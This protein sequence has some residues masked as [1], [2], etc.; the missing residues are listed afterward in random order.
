MVNGRLLKWGGRLLGV[1]TDRVRPAR[2]HQVRDM[3][4]GIGMGKSKDSAI[5]LGPALV[6]VDELEPCRRD[7]RLAME[8]S[9]TVNGEQLTRG[10]LDRMDWSFGELIAYVS[11]GTDVPPGSVI[12]SGTVPFG[13]LLEHVDT[14]DPA[15]FRRR[16]RPG[17][18]VS[19][20]G[21][22]LGETAQTV[23]EGWASHDSAPV[24]EVVR[25]VRT[26]RI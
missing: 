3:A 17:D 7:G 8:L 26:A 13:C 14:A 6:T 18:V 16:L 9:A 11:R 22:G 25:S 1:D 5:T 4:Q 19:L 10:R 2:D 20:R 24:R 23:R 15:D 12:G 21:E